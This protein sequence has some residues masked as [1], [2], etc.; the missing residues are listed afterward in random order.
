MKSCP[1][2][3]LRY[4]DESKFCFVD[5]G[6]LEPLKD[7][8]IG[9]TLNGRY[10]IENVLGEGGM[11]TVYRARQQLVDR[12]CAVKILNPALARDKNVRERFRREAKSA[13]KLAHPNVI[14]VFDEGD[15]GDGTSFM[16]ME[17]LKGE[18]LD[19]I[20]ARG[21]IPLQRAMPIMIQVARGIARAHDLEVIHRDLKPENIYI[22]HRDDGSDLVKLLDFGIA[23]SMQ[24]S[25]LTGVGEVFGTPQYMAPERITS[26][27]AGGS[28]DL[29]AI[30][31]I[32]FEMLTGTL[33]FEANDVPSFLLKHLKEPPPKISSRGVSVP[34]ELETLI[35]TLMAKDPK[36]RPVDAHRVHNDLVAISTR[37]GI[38]PPP[39]ISLDQQAQQRAPVAALAP[40]TLDHWTRRIA[41]FDQMVVRAFPGGA[42]QDQRQMLDSVRKLVGDIT[43]I[44]RVSV[45]DQHKLE[46]IAQRA[47]E[48][49]ERFGRAVDA[50]GVDASKARD[51]ARTARDGVA[52]YTAAVKQAQQMGRQLHTD[53]LHWEGRSGFA[54]PYAEL[55][56]SYRKLADLMDHWVKAADLE[57]QAVAWAEAKE[58][59]VADLDFQIQELRTQLGKFEASTEQ[60]HAALEQRVAEAG[61]Q[62]AKMEEALLDL[63]SRFCAPLRGR[64]ELGSIFSELEAES[65]PQSFR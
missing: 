13:K 46:E 58:Q 40:V 44:R 26:I 23:R 14:D 4:P 2:C 38:A 60:E 62:A 29:Y 27:D 31:V 21:A 32:F 34:P 64:P 33:P 28:Q 10:F 37:V 30:G 6:V 11:A 8:R 1:K 57:K 41:L 22:A 65:G 35:D 45:D 59:E 47:R 42:A 9:T 63:G 54:T 17:L 19:T 52:P 48:A 16:V 36:Q 50:L 51:E 49:R 15:T 39:E 7:P 53:V 61:K 20:V 5:G 25:R 55:S 56:L 18:P 43:G 3:N 24:D 12:P